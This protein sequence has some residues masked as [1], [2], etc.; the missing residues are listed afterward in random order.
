MFPEV[1]LV[2]EEDGDFAAKAFKV[3][4]DEI[5]KQKP[6]PLLVLL[7]EVAHEIVLR[8]QL[9]QADLAGERLPGRGEEGRD[10]VHSTFGLLLR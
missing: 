6:G 1:D 2:L 4:V 3:F 5:W 10:D 7:V 9:L 8:D